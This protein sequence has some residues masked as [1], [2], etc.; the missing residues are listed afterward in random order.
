MFTTG[1]ALAVVLSL[2]LVRQGVNF[3][4]P[5]CCVEIYPSSRLCRVAKNPEKTQRCVQSRLRFCTIPRSEMSSYI[6]TQPTETIPHFSD[7]FFNGVKG[8]GQRRATWK[9][10]P[11]LRF[12]HTTTVPGSTST[13]EVSGFYCN[14]VSTSVGLS[15]TSPVCSLHSTCRTRR[16]TSSGLI[17]NLKDISGLSQSV[18]PWTLVEYQYNSW[19]YTYSY[20]RWKAT[21][22]KPT[23]TSVFLIRVEQ[24]MV[25]H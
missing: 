15:N 13:M 2:S 7:I 3:V 23:L 9:T 18:L 14:S 5:V 11:Q 17:Q 20:I 16:V 24:V 22:S 10:Q 19:N 6:S 4:C 25:Q 8:L 1:W 21:A 12:R